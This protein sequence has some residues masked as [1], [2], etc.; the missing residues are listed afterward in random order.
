[1]NVTEKI[2]TAVATVTSESTSR[3]W[4]YEPKVPEKLLKKNK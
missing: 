4:L 1:M 3:V 2:L